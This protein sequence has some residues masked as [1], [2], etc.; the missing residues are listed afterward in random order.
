MKNFLSILLLTTIVCCWG[1]SGGGEDEPIPIPTPKP[2]ER[3]KVEVTTTPPIIAKE[4]GTTKVAFTSSESWTLDIT[5]GRT[6]SWCN[7][8]PVSGDKGTNTLTIT[9]TVNDTYDDRNA[10]ITIKAGTTT[11]SFTITQKQK[12]GLIVTPNKVEVKA[13]GDDV[14]IEVKANVEYKAEIEKSTQSWISS[15]DSRGLTTKILIFT[16]KKNEKTESRQ[17]YIKIKGGE[18]LTETITIYQEGKKQTES[19]GNNEINVGIGSWENAN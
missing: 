2:D 16:V 4:G 11:Q 15:N 3:P 1:C 13:E 8:S 5:E 7:V 18:N 17:G 9:T 19:N 6:P 12:D 10:K 14:A